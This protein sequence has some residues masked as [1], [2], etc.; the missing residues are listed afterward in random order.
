MY[1]GDNDKTVILPLTG[2]GQRPKPSPPPPAYKPN[3]AALSIDKL[4]NL[5][6]NWSNPLISSASSL[7]SLVSKLRNLAFHDKVDELQT[8]LVREMTAFE[9]NAMQKGATEKEIMAGRYFICSLIDETVMNTPWGNQSNWSQHSLLSR[10]YTESWGGENF[11]QIL[12]KM[13]QQPSQHLNLLELAY[14]CLSMGFE[15]KYRV[16]ND[17]DGLRI[18]EQ[19]RYELYEIIK[20]TRGEH[21]RELSI[22]WKGLSDLRNPLRRYAPLW[23]LILVTGSLLVMIYLGFVYAANRASDSVYSQLMAVIQDKIEPPPSR[24][25]LLE[26]THVVQKLEPKPVIDLT[27]RFRRL[28]AEEISQ[29]MVKVL[30]GPILRISNAFASGSEK[31]KPDYRP[32]LVK[33]AK[34]LEA[35]SSKIQVIGHTDNQPIRFSARF[36]SNW[37]LSVARAENIASIISDSAE[38]QGRVVAEGRSDADPIVKNDTPENRARNRRVDIH[39]W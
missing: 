15:G 39:I 11:F 8:R 13:K 38:L 9:N 7:L 14:L 27:T 16:S 2:S 17:R 32:M 28:L 5:S 25:F 34:E 12:E 37:H 22:N 26:P 29:K 18:I 21:H 10:F 1:P 24:S 6:S 3:A 36:K 33:I 35:G 23:M 31:V 4:E 20:R 19:L 30:D